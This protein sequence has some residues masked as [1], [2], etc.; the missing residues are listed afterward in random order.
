MIRDRFLKLLSSPHLL[1]CFWNLVFI[2]CA[3]GTIILVYI[4]HKQ[5]S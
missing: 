2:S 1:K 4:K 3:E 5:K